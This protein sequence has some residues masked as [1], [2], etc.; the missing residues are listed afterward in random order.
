MSSCLELDTREHSPAQRPR[1][2]GVR[3]DQEAR[4]ETSTL[5]ERAIE[6]LSLASVR[7]STRRRRHPAGRLEW[8]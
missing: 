2:D 5:G 7:L 1:P 4:G 6:G 3:A 8:T